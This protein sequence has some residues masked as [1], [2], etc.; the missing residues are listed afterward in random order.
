MGKVIIPYYV[1]RERHGRRIGYW[2]PSRS[3]KNAGFRLVTCGEDGPAA[4]AIAQKYAD[5]WRLSR[6]NTAKPQHPTGSLADIF[7]RYRATQ[8]WQR[9]S[10]RTQEDW[11]RGWRYIAPY[12]SDI[13]PA[14]INFE[15]ID[16]WYALLL[17]QAGVSEAFRAMKI[18][19]AMWVVASAFGLCG[20]QADPSR[21]IRR[22]TPQ[23]RSTVITG[24]DVGRM[25]RHAWRSG[26]HGMACAISIA[27]DSGLSPVDVRSLTPSQ[28][29]AQGRWGAFQ[30]ARAKTG[31]AAL[32]TL[33]RRSATLLRWHQALI[34]AEAL[35]NAPIIRTRAG[36]AYT[37]NT[38]AKDF[39]VVRKGALPDRDCKMMDIRRSVAVEARAGGATN[40]Q[41]AA[42]LANRMDVNAFLEK[43][44]MPVDEA[45]VRSVDEARAAARRQ[46]PP[47][48]KKNIGG[49]DV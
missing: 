47:G 8:A 29:R 14:K 17:D 18:W 13:A 26:Y 4:W 25:I 49:D 27:W 46:T 10:P 45:S 39:R 11:H 22:Q 6:Q 33:S 38:L 36:A 41:I 12:F 15:V 21:G 30:V 37:K 40:E 44:Y 24:D 42:K 34:G 28:R 43:T 48:H 9:K 7:A 19:R 2:Q 3:M 31:K 35:P 23:G 20:G 5:A 1:V 16:E 32:A